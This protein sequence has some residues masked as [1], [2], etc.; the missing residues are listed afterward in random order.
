MCLCLAFIPEC[1]WLASYVPLPIPLGW[2]FLSFIGYVGAPVFC[3]VYSWLVKRKIQMNASV[4]KG[5]AFVYGAIVVSFLHLLLVA[6]L[7]TLL[8]I[9]GFPGH[10]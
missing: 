8:V 9:A 5:L 3:V 4:Y 7:I 6:Y 10:E 1:M 2:V